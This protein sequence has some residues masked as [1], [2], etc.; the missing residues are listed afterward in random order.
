MNELEELALDSV[1]TGGPKE[2]LTEQ[3]NNNPD[4]PQ[5]DPVEPS[6]SPEK[7]SQDP[8]NV[9][10][11]GAEQT[12]IDLEPDV[13]LEPDNTISTNSNIAVD[14][15]GDDELE[16]PFLDDNYSVNEFGGILTG[17]ESPEA[18]N[19][20]RGLGFSNVKAFVNWL[21]KNG[22]D[23]PVFG[24]WIKEHKLANKKRQE[25][26]E[27]I[28][29]I[30]DDPNLS[31]ADKDKI[32]A[33]NTNP[34]T[35]ALSGEEQAQKIRK[36]LD[37]AGVT[38]LSDN[39]PYIML[40]NEDIDLVTRELF[41]DPMASDGIL[42]GIRVIGKKKGLLDPDN[43]KIVTNEI[44]NQRLS[45]IYNKYANAFK[46]QKGGVDRLTEDMSRQ[47]A[48][49]VMLTDDKALQRILSV[50]PGEMLPYPYIQAMKYMFNAENS[51]LDVLIQ[52]AI[53]D[54]SSV[55]IFNAREQFEIVANL[56][57]KM[58][59]IKTDI[60]RALNSFRFDGSDLGPD[61][62]VRQTR[63]RPKDWEFSK[64]E[65]TDGLQTEAELFA[66]HA[67][68]YLDNNGGKE[69][70]LEFFRRLKDAPYHARFKLTKDYHRHAKNGKIGLFFQSFHE[71]WINALLSSPITHMRNIIGNSAMLV[72][73]VAEDYAIGTVNSALQVL[74]KQNNG[75]KLSE[76][77]DATG[78]MI[79]A[80]W[81]A[82]YS[83]AKVTAGGRKPS[84]LGSNT[85]LENTRRVI[86][87]DSYIDPADQPYLAHFIDYAGGTIN[88]FTKAL[89]AEDTF[90][91]VLAQRYD[92]KKQAIRS[93]KE[94]GLTG[95][96]YQNYVA[97]FIADPPEEALLKSQ[98]EASYITFQEELGQT[99]KSG[100]KVINNT[101]GL[102]YM[103]PF[104]KTPYNIAR[105]TF[106]DGTPL[107]L[108]SEE[109]RRVL[110]HGT[111]DEKSKLFARQGSALALMT[112]A[113]T[114]AEDEIIVDDVSLPKL[115]GG[116][117]KS[118]WRDKNA[119]EAKK[120]SEMAGI[121]S[122]SYRVKNDDGS[123]SYKSLQGLEPFSSWMGLSADVSLILNSPEY[124]TQEEQDQA[125]TAL[126]FATINS[127][128]SK[129]F[130]QGIQDMF[131]TLAE[132]EEN[133]VQTLEKVALGFVP[134]IL[135][136]GARI[137]D[138]FQREA[139]TFVDRF[140]K[141]VP[142]LREGLPAKRSLHGKKIKEQNNNLIWPSTEY[143]VT[144]N[145]LSNL[146]KL[147]LEL[148]KAPEGM[149]NKINFQGGVFELRDPEEIDFLYRAYANDYNAEVEDKLK[150]NSI[151]TDNVKRW[152]DS[153]YTD[154]ESR[155][156][157]IK[158]ANFIVLKY[159]KKTLA[160]IYSSPWA[161]KGK[162]KDLAKSIKNQ[163]Q[164]AIQ[165]NNE[166][167]RRKGG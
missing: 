129:T 164:K 103:V 94:R 148:R 71:F 117:T 158:E 126:L 124:F 55:N 128:T 11:V 121:K 50:K 51:R 142:G 59:G 134:N 22:E 4:V 34:E 67:E 163:I 53:E 112:W 3:A 139:I 137:T 8:V 78:A 13:I 58:S 62:Q 159:R 115:Q 82:L 127:L 6:A 108:F 61:V 143:K 65:Q 44:V 97:E 76:V 47:L 105:V 19:L 157:A 147:W 72:K 63:G 95:K 9:D 43:R 28:Y 153:Q 69:N 104:F 132:P 37:D 46:S 10:P 45:Y 133:F 156:E 54:N 140:M 151:F 30:L 106:R 99:A 87:A 41:N 21:S 118:T 102:K 17:D 29:D 86:K 49:I 165:E 144:T 64:V 123:Y 120:I 101:P 77:N 167:K 84:Q 83:M 119:R 130:A 131:N 150:D 52:K 18:V 35:K 80:F 90:F 1:A 141:R 114:M 38:Y 74:G 125:L 136:Q 25:I 85:K 135:V 57:L 60:G 16:N 138:D 146:E 36:D 155:D 14:N 122:Y 75:L 66:Q 88:T 166:R 161:Y 73:N 20:A 7:K 70:T 109:F 2:V 31:K 92:I 79:M 98:K 107:G 116:A 113:F 26:N 42:G 56:H 68:N 12:E 15:L 32:I 23:L 91:K 96:K 5:V 93:A 160:K 110:F 24:D 33:E 27:L 162:D 40:G 48:D 81:E 89:D 100:Q 39:N 152:K 145:T 154:I 149:T 111:R